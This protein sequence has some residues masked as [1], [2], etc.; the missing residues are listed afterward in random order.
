MK[1]HRSFGVTNI[2][3]LGALATS[4]PATAWAQRV[5]PAVRVDSLLEG[6][7]VPK[8]MRFELRDIVIGNRSVLDLVD[9]VP[10]HPPT[11]SQYYSRAIDSVVVTLRRPSLIGA[12][13]QLAQH[14][15][16]TLRLRFRDPNRSFIR[17]FHD[18]AARFLHRRFEYEV[19]LPLHSLRNPCPVVTQVIYRTVDERVHH[20][21][22]H[23]GQTPGT[24]TLNEVLDLL[25]SDQLDAF[26]ATMDPV[27]PRE[28]CTETLELLK[29][30]R[31]D[32][33]A[34]FGFGSY[35]VHPGLR[36][37]LDVI[38]K[39]IENS[40]A[41]WPDQDVLIEAV[42]YGDPVPVRTDTGG[43][44]VSF[45]RSGIPAFTDRHLV[46][47][48]RYDWCANDRGRGRPRYLPLDSE[49]V[50]QRVGP[51]IT[52]NCELGAVRSFFVAWYLS[53]RIG[54]V[55]DY[56][57]ATGGVRM[58]GA[59]DSSKRMVDVVFT[60]RGGRRRGPTGR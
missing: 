55:A 45:S 7:V 56:R 2:C 35:E 58:E 6:V 11:T 19:A 1:L 39:S 54:R 5:L 48:V 28:E 26:L 50:G 52:N 17:W 3:L 38:A 9:P 25:R 43:I 44:N 36:A 15:D 47:D 14:S 33:A 30:V 40:R 37:T 23:S 13:E 4:A 29:L 12:L 51:K 42:G 18:H 8:P 31:G 46:P 49:G 20:S 59:T 57:Y 32:S 41:E 10:R 24:L 22:I 21:L 60:L 53:G 16:S 27:D 34:S